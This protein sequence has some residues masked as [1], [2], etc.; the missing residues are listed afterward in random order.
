MWDLNDKS[1]HNHFCINHPVKLWILILDTIL[2]FEIL[3]LRNYIISQYGV[4]IH[5][6]VFNLKNVIVV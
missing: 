4:N 3:I 1:S 5:N 6:T 2:M